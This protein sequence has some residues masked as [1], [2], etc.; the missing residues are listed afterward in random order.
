MSERGPS[1]AQG[2]GGGR[3]GRGWKVDAARSL[4]R[5]LKPGGRR[6]GKLVYV[7]EQGRRRRLPAE[8]ELTSEEL[9]AAADALSSALGAPDPDLA[10]LAAVE[11]LTELRAAG[12]VSEEDYKRERRRLMGE[13]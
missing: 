10:R 5:L 11:R 12:A 7:D 3:R 1:G 9:R 13:G 8:E 4:A 2:P 6:G